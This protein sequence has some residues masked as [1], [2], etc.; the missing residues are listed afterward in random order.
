MQPFHQIAV[1]RGR[2]RPR[3]NDQEAFNQDEQLK[4]DTKRNV[5]E[6]SRYPSTTSYSD[7]SDANRGAEK[8]R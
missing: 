4:G 8:E 1:W 5:L 6:N 2:R 7:V 3:G